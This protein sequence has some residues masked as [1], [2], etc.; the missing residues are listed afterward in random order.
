MYCSSNGKKLDQKVTSNKIS[1]FAEDYQ[2]TKKEDKVKVTLKDMKK[3]RNSL[4]HGETTK[5]NGNLFSSG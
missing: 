3:N 2:L 4:Q 5:T 1:S